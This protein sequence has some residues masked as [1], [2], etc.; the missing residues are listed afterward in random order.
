MPTCAFSFGC[1]GAALY[2]GRCNRHYQ[3]Y[4]KYG[5]DR[6]DPPKMPERFWR[7]VRVTDG[8][9]E[10][11]GACVEGYGYFR[12]GTQQKKAH[13]VAYELVVGPIPDGLTIDH[14][15]QNKGCVNPAHMEPVTAAENLSRQGQRMA[16]CR[17]GHPFIPENTYVSR[18]GGRSRRVCLEC[19]W[20][21]KRGLHPS[22][23]R[24]ASWTPERRAALSQRMRAVRAERFWST[25]KRNGTP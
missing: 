20:E 19:Y 13:R 4:Q 24:A 1:Q 12:M 5:E 10:W 15:C 16:A 22:P 2:R 23:R 25:R 7:Y 18:S 3:R 14:L 8:C 11:T 21:S 17:R 9:W 6:P